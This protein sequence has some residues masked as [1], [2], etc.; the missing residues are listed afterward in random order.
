MTIRFGERW[1]LMPRS[2]MNNNDRNKNSIVNS[3]PVGR[4]N[5]IIFHTERISM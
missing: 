3:N 4:K 2:K 1:R 5:P